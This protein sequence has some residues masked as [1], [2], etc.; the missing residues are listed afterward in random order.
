MSNKEK[1]GDFQSWE[2][3]T[4]SS[5]LK[6]DLVHELV[7]LLLSRSGTMESSRSV[8]SLKVPVYTQSRT[9]GISHVQFLVIYK[10]RSQKLTFSS[11]LLAFFLAVSFFRLY[12]SLRV[13]VRVV[14]SDRLASFIRSRTS[15]S[16]SLLEVD[17][18]ER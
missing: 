11:A 2:P 17:A 9:K 7:L 14:S 3:A 12:K 1:T 5:I 13:S 8:T 16:W 4:E 10:I 15:V 18:K 6:A